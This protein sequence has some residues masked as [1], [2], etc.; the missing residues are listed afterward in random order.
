MD[1]TD[2]Q[3]NPQ[4]RSVTNAPPAKYFQEEI[5]EIKGINE[6]ILVSKSRSST[7]YSKV[8][9]EHAKLEDF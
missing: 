1:M 8:T 5:E 4:L 6:E 3:M 7:L 2:E 9:E